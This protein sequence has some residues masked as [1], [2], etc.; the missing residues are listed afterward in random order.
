MKYIILVNLVLINAILS[1]ISVMGNLH[2][3]GT[4]YDEFAR[5][6]EDR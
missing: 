1:N 2:M 5:E 6:E 3:N 4:C